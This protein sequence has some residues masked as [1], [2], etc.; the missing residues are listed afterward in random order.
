M[1]INTVLICLFIYSFVGWLY[2]SIICSM[3][4]E[5]KIINRGFL[6]GPYVPIYGFGAVLVIQLFGNL[7][8]LFQ[9]FIYSMIICTTIEYI[10]S[11][12]MEKMFNAIWWDYSNFPFNYRGRISLYASTLFGFLSV[13]L[14]NHAHPIIINNI[15]T[16]PVSIQ[17]AL[18]VIILIILLTDLIL[19]L[20]AWTNFNNHLKTLHSSLNNVQSSNID[21][22][23][24]FVGNLITDEM[25]DFGGDLVINIRNFNVTIKKNELRLISAFPKLKLKQYNSILTRI[26]KIIK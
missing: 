15:S 17:N 10:T 21:K 12:V 16:L 2:E 23:N 4:N 14:I 9:I 5:R 3:I 26:K 6:I 11:V 18:S 24:Q 22:I 7:S 25:A 1:N 20:N 19:T 13:I 8:S